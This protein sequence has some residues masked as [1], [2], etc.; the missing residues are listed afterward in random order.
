MNNKSIKNSTMKSSGQFEYVSQRVKQSRRDV[1]K[2]LCM[3]FIS[4]VS[5]FTH[6]FLS[7]YLVV[8][9]ICFFVCWFPHHLQRILTFTVRYFKI[10]LKPGSHLYSLIELLYYTSGMIKNLSYF[11][12]FIHFISFF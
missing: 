5:K 6:Y 8:V 4:V 1:I 2:M 11:S 7:I 12:N 9:V 10:V 3:L